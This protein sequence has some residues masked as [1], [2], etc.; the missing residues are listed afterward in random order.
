MKVIEDSK[1]VI[2]NHA[3]CFGYKPFCYVVPF[4]HKDYEIGM[5]AH[6][7]YELNIVISGHGTHYIEGYSYKISRGHV[8]VIP[9]M[10][11]HGY[12]N[13]GSLD[14]YHL[15]INNKFIS[16]YN[17]ELLS[18]PS[19]SQLFNAEPLVRSNSEHELFLKL[20]TD[21][22]DELNLKLQ[23]LLT[24]SGQESVELEIM[25]N[26]YALYIISQICRYYSRLYKL[27][28]ITKN[29]IY[30][31]MDSIRVIYDEYDQKLSIEYLSGIA[32]V[33]RTS[34]IN[35]F[36]EFM[37]LTPNEFITLHRISRAKAL[38]TQTSMSVTDISLQVGFYDSSHFSK[39]FIRYEQMSP[40]EYRA[41]YNNKIK[42]S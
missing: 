26:A 25:K 7:F 21:Q 6:D 32:G 24:I 29:N 42:L 30:R 34:Y 14:V 22:M 41:V 39:V 38:L 11:K 3:D 18:L 16:R 12:I 28:D 1:Q 23:E 9:P 5:H 27:K 40:K 31:I 20:D 10:I 2:F 33:S 35:M 37:Q 17:E 8:F 36:K 19:Y 15:L 13:D 4:I